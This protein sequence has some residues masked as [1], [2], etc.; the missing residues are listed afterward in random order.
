MLKAAVKT[1]SGEVLKES[2]SLGTLP[3]E[4]DKDF[5]VDGKRYEVLSV[6]Q[7]NGDDSWVITVKENL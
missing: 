6:L 4:G 7:I 1:S 2:F 5:W 3:E